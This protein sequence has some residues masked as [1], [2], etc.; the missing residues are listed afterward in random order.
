MSREAGHGLTGPSALEGVA[1]KVSAT[2]GEGST[3]E[4]SASKITW[5]LAAFW[6]LGAVG[7]KISVPGQLLARNSLGPLPCG[8]L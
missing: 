7:L 6:S 5:L 2:G 4:G 8:A 3:G 1:I